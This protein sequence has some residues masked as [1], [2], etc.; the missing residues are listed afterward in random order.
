MEKTKKVKAEKVVVADVKAEVTEIDANIVKGVI[1]WQDALRNLRN[2]VN[3]LQLNA[4]TSNI[5]DVQV[6][7]SK[8]AKV[9]R[10]KVE[11]A[12]TIPARLN[13]RYN[14]FLAK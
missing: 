6:I 12:E 13:R 2:L 4:E 9:E 5:K 14:T 1:K 11:K 3:L 10:E 7:L 8:L